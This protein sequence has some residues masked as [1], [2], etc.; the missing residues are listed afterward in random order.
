M[1]FKTLKKVIQEI[2]KLIQV[3][4]SFN[5]AAIYYSICILI[6]T[7]FECEI[8]SLYQKE[9]LELIRIYVV[10]I[11]RKLEYSIKFLRSVICI[12]T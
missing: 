7:C 2:F 10:P 9:E 11:S 8:I 4:L 6:S 5:Q 1:N 12:T 3:Q